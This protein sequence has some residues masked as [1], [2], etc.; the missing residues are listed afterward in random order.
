MKSSGESAPRSGCGQRTSASTAAQPPVVE[1]DLRLEDELELAGGDRAAELGD[2]RQPL[3]A[4]LVEV[5]RSRRRPRGGRP[6]PARARRRRGAA[7]RRRWSPCSG[8]QAIAGVRAER[9]A[10]RRGS[11]PARAARRAPARPRRRSRRRRRRGARTARTRRPPRRAATSRGPGDRGQPA[12]DLDQHEVAAAVPERLV[13]LLEARQPDHQHADLL[14]LALARGA[15]R[16]R[17]RARR[18]RGWRAR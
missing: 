5:A 15:A 1:L 10:R 16:A 3:H 13:D 8:W 14:A 18:P 4:V 17:A 12:G 6:S 7:A 9:R 11:S 2:E